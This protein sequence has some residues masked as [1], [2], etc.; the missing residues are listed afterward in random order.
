MTAK[1]A[2][3]PPRTNAAQRRREASAASGIEQQRRDRDRPAAAEHLGREPV[4]RLRED[5]DLARVVRERAPQLAPG[6]RV[7]RGRA[8]ERDDRERHGRRSARAS[9]T[10]AARE[11][12]VVGVREQRSRDE[13][14]AERQAEEDR[15]GRVDDRKR[16]PAGRDRA[17]P[18]EPRREQVGEDEREHGRDEQL[19][20]RRWP[21]S[22]R[23]A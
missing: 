14:A 4:A 12:L 15:V 8:D 3:E 20:A 5:V 18:G 16:E 1:T 23:K 19:A 6:R 9:A 2:I 10:R 21:G 7:R 22:A 13:E 17:E 11:R